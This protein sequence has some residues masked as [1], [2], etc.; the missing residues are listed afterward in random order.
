MSQIKRLGPWVLS[1][2]LVLMCGTAS[3]KDKLV[4]ATWGGVWGDSLDKNVVQPFQ[5]ANDVEIVIHRQRSAADTMTKIIAEKGAPTID[6][7]MTI[8]GS[9]YAVAKEGLAEPM[10]EK[11]VPELVNFPKS[12]V[13]TMDG[14]AQWVNYGAQKIGLIFRTD[15]VK[16]P[17][18][19]NF[20]WMADPSIK[21]KLA[22]P[23]PVW[24]YAAFLS[25][26]A[27]AKAGDKTKLDA[28]FDTAKKIGPNV[29]VIY[30]TTGEA[31]R[32]LTTGE[33]GVAYATATTSSV[34][35][36]ENVP[37]VEFVTVA[38]APLFVA[39]ESVLAVKGGPNGKAL[40]MKFINYFLSP[41]VLAAYTED[42]GSPPTN[43]KSPAPSKEKVPYPMTIQELE[44]AQIT[45][46][47]QNLDAINDR[48]KRDIAPLFGG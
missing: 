19:A 14:K 2:A 38:D 43:M 8:P 5:A 37:N 42:I 48:W 26:A 35:L 45:D 13:G 28:G 22:L 24:N 21:K 23:T 27:M 36:K 15:I 6:V 32:L 44:K 4:V 16:V 31:V 33:V 7:Y 34:L 20:D 3:A 11:E 17:A 39:P 41:K 18:K 1:A 30:G 40:A 9:A 47:N 12:M 10:T 46:P 25:Q 29:Q